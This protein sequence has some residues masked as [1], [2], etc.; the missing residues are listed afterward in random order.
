[1]MELGRHV[2]PGCRLS[3]ESL[4]LIRRYRERNWLWSVGGENKHA[5]QLVYRAT[6]R[7]WVTLARPHCGQK[8]VEVGLRENSREEIK[9][10][11]GSLAVKDLV[12]S[13]PWRRFNPVP[14]NFAMSQVWPKGK[15]RERDS[16]QKVKPFW[17]I[18]SPKRNQF[19]KGGRSWK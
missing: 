4:F 10:F 14:G 7:R 16:K 6:L 11:P 5:E 8:L 15:K 1:M 18:G 9:E 13:L 2:Q 12:L 3:F 19:F 17:R